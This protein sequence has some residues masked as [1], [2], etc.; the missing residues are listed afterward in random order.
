M[1]CMYILHYNETA[2]NIIYD[3]SLEIPLFQQPCSDSET[4]T[5]LCY[6]GRDSDISQPTDSTLLNKTKNVLSRKTR[7]FLPSWYTQFPWIHFCKAKLKVFSFHCM[8][9]SKGRTVGI[10]KAKADSTFISTGDS[11]W[12]KA[13]EKF[14]DHERSTSHRDVLFTLYNTGNAV[15]VSEQLQRKAEN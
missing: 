11:N 4:W 15:P 13:V 10:R 14:K 6:T 3:P 8:I 9:A 5:A 7:C 1:K 2:D 12:K